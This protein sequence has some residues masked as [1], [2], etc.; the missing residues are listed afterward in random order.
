MKR[1]GAGE[2]VRGS[3]VDERVLKVDERS[4]EADEPVS[5]VDEL[6]SNSSLLPAPCPS[7]SPISHQSKQ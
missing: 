4:S 1:Q 3:E 7:A 2:V 5:K 6:D